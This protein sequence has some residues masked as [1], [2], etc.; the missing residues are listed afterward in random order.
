MGWAASKA[1]WATRPSASL[2]LNRAAARTPAPKATSPAASGAPWPLL[3]AASTSACG[4][5]F[6]RSAACP[7][8][9]ATPLAAPDTDEATPEARSP[10]VPAV[11]P[12]P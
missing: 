12:S 10:T 7:A 1:A 11:M 9:P 5:S 2:P 4:A 8:V 3:V 6:T